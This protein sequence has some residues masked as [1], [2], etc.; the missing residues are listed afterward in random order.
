M[1]VVDQIILRQWPTK[2]EAAKMAETWQ[3]D[4][5]GVDNILDGNAVG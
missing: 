4:V 5:D 1:V 2:M 3:D